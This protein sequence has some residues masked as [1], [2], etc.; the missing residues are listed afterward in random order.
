MTEEK[1]DTA[2]QIGS[3]VAG[4]TSWCDGQYVVEYD[5]SRPGTAPDGSRMRCHL[6]TT[7]DPAK[8]TLY[9]KVEAHALWTSVDR[10]SPV[11]ADGKPN[12][13]FTA[14]SVVFGPPDEQTDAIARLTREV[15]TGHPHGLGGIS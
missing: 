1:R 5:A 4:G 6:I 15:Q 13:P 11:R 14:F 8:A 9:T 3:L 2:I 12:C 7:P 10:R